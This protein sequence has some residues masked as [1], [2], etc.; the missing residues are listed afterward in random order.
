MYVVHFCTPYICTIYVYIN[1]CHD[2][3]GPVCVSVS[4]VQG[5]KELQ[6]SFFQALVLLLFDDVDKLS[7]ADISQATNI[8][9]TRCYPHSH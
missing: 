7:F 8:G 2:Y 6:V 4:S 1:C 9:T 3:S 5:E